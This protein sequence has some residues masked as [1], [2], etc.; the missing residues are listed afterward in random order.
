MTT[1]PGR[2]EKIMSLGLSE[3]HRGVKALAL[4]T[5]LEDDQNHVT[6]TTDQAQIR[7]VY[8][9]LGETTLGGLLAL[10]RAR[11]TLHLSALNETERRAFLARFDRVFQRGG[12]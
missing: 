10:P 5:H 3:F 11:V 6:V 9:P 8:E 7:I 12:G 1:P 2:V 4:D